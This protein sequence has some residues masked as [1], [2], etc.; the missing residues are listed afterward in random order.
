MVVV[1]VVWVWWVVS[2]VHRG[3]TG[4]ACTVLVGGFL[5]LDVLLRAVR[6]AGVSEVCGC[7]RGVR[8]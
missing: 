7:E 5:L 8:V 2:D 4:V 3:C 6:C 1:A